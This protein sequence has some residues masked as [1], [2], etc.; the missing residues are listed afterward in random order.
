MTTQKKGLIPTV[1]GHIANLVP[2]PPGKPI[3]EFEREY[4]VKNPIKMAS[5]E[6]PLG[7]SPM[8]MEAVSQIISSLHRYPDGSGYYLK[9]KLAEIYGVDQSQVVLGNGSNE[10]IDFLIRVFVDKSSEVISSDPSFLV[11]RKMV[12]AAGGNNIMIPLK[13]SCHD[14]DAISRAV[15]SKTRLIFLD[16]P[17]NPMGTVIQARRFRD[18]LQNIPED[19]LVVLDEAYMEF[20][21]EPDTPRGVDYIHKDRRIIFLR[22]FSKAY[23]LAGLRAGYGIMDPGVA[24][25]LEKV[26]QPFNVN[27]MAQAAALA[28]LDDKKH[29]DQTRTVT[30]QG[31]DELF[32]EL[33][34]MG[35]TPLPS[36]TNYILVDVGTDAGKIYKKML[37][38]GIIIRSMASYGLANYIRITVGLPEE[39]RKCIAALKK[40]LDRL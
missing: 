6:N 26:R 23:G 34:E 40:V 29:L 25:S 18:F 36:Q 14:L 21:R 33:R 19:V 7:P 31:M 17:N 32:L 22:T 3:E 13:D 5:N 16:N 9:A 28:A 15:T 8:A 35:C 4:G 1:P 20:V 2:Y 12:Q 37:K 11:Y 27:I 10:I 30:W 24:E 38:E 39:N